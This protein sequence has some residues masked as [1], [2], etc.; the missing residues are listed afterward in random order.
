M[1]LFSKI[2]NPW[3]VGLVLFFIVFIGY[4]VGFVIFAS[5]QKMDLVRADYY[6]QEIRFQQ[7]I[8]RVKRTAPVMAEAGIDYD[9]TGEVVTVS[10]PVKQNDI[11]GTVSF[12]RPSNAE[13]DTNVELGLDPAGRQS[14][15][16]RAL[17]T[18]LWKVRI[19]WKSAGQEYYFEKPIVI[20]RTAAS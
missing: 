20:K 13:M 6:D 4:I 8:D 10:L 9:R 3:P 1:K 19:Q 16:V 5:R 7:Q 17:S 12:Y 18:G 11:S 14:L 15:S 2:K